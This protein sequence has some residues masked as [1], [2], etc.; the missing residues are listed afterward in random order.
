MNKIKISANYSHLEKIYS[1]PISDMASEPCKLL[2]LVCNWFG[3]SW[4]PYI[5][6]SFYKDNW[7]RCSHGDKILASLVPHFMYLMLTIWERS[8]AIC[9]L[10]GS[11]FISHSCV[12][13]GSQTVGWRELGFLSCCQGAAASCWLM[14]TASPSHWES[15]LLLIPLA[16]DLSGFAPAV[17]EAV[18][19]GLL[20]PG[21]WSSICVRHLPAFCHLTCLRPNAQT[22]LGKAGKK[23]IAHQSSTAPESTF[24]FQFSASETS[25]C[26]QIMWDTCQNADSNP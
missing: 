22:S 25:M 6:L 5:P 16:T 23:P 24:V 2:E 20:I 11:K 15:L 12:A 7:G 21:K 9:L 10:P 8:D 3:P 17:S 19:V 14:A 4:W 18:A 13:G 1:T 26:L